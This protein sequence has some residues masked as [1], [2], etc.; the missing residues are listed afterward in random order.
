MEI[1]NNMLPSKA[2]ENVRIF[3]NVVTDTIFE[4]SDEYKIL[5]K[6]IETYEPEM[7]IIVDETINNLSKQD[8]GKYII[9]YLN[10]KAGKRFKP[11][12]S[13]LKFI[14]A[15]LNE[16]YTIEDL[17][18][19]IDLKVADNKA[20]KFE[21]LYLRPETLFNALKFQGYINQE[22]G[23]FNEKKEPKNRW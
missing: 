7:E 1:K 8:I 15:R 13:N 19:V 3:I 14:N 21:N 23:K 12:A 5:K 4:K 11:V 17:K 20:G 9:A 16:G 18:Y 2:L 6:F 10:E 22:K